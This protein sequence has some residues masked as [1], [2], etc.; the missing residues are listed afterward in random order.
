M[1]HVPHSTRKDI[2]SILQLPGPH[3]G[4]YINENIYGFITK[5]TVFIKKFTS[6]RHDIRR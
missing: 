4:I 1:V 3:T 2:R 5:R 6:L